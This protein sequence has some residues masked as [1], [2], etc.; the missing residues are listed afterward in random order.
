MA[1]VRLKLAPWTVITIY[2]LFSKGSRR[3]RNGRRLRM[4]IKHAV[5]SSGSAEQRFYFGGSGIHTGL[6]KHKGRLI[7]NKQQLE[8]YSQHLK[9][10]QRFPPRV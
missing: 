7:D 4:D 6:T 10:Q 1:G 9:S 8:R 3:K 2:V 5:A